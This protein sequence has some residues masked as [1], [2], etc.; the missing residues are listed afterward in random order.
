LLH[1]K[2]NEQHEAYAGFGILYS[3]DLLNIK[4]PYENPKTE[5][6]GAAGLLL[7]GGWIFRFREQLFIFLDTRI[8]MRFYQNPMVSI[9]P[10]AGVIFRRYSQE[11]VKKW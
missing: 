3:F 6:Y 7:S 1:R 11:V 8:E 9:A 5:K 4:K 10:S 2:F